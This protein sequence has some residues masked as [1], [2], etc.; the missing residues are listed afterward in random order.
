[1][2]LVIMQVQQLF[3]YDQSENTV[4]FYFGTSDPALTANEKVR[5]VGHFI[6]IQHK[7]LILTM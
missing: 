3:H 5:F 6:Q 4:R 1:M 2:L 7:M